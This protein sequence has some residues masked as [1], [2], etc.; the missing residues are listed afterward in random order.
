[1]SVAPSRFQATE[2]A[3]SAEPPARTEGTSGYHLA[4]AR[5]AWTATPLL[6]DHLRRL[7]RNASSTWKGRMRAQSAT[8]PAKLHA[9]RSHLPLKKKGAGWGLHGDRYRAPYPELYIYAPTGIRTP[10]L[11]LRGLRPGPLD[12]GGE[13][14]GLYHKDPAAT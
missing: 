9:A 1:M 14:D 13:R 3:P 2:L 12:D 6:A 4:L 10:V 7:P 5:G 8:P 11:A